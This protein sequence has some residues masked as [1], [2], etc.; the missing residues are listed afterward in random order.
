MLETFVDENRLDVSPSGPVGD[1]GFT[2]AQLLKKVHPTSA[3]PNG[4]HNPSVAMISGPAWS[5]SMLWLRALY[6]TLSV[7]QLLNS[8]Q[9]S[10]KPR[11]LAPSYSSP[12]NW[13][14]M[15]SGSRR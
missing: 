1:S 4:R 12:A 2:F 11:A 15:I 7:Q 13:A 8:S 6:S 3:Y 10:W 14:R 9:T 5:M